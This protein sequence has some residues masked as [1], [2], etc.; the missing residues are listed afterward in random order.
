MRIA[1]RR[2]VS[3]QWHDPWGRVRLGLLV[4]VLVLLVG[5]V[6]YVILGLGVLDAMYQTVT[7]VSTVGFREMVPESDVDTPFKV[8]TIMMILG[9]TG[10]VL[11]TVG[12]L[13]ESLVEGGLTDEIR[14]RRMQQEIDDLE[15]HIIVCGIGQV[16]SAIADELSR[17][18]RE[19]VLVDKREVVLGGGRLF[20]LGDSTDDGVLVKAG[21][22]RASTLVLAMDSDA[23]NLF[24]TLSARAIRPDLFIV[25]R[26]SLASTEPKLLQAG[27]DRVVS[28]H[29]IGGTRMAALVLQP[30]VADF[31]DVVMHDRQL[32]VR[33]SEVPLTESSPFAG[34]QLGVCDI[35]GRSGATVLGLVRPDGTFVTNPQLETELHA[36]DVLIALGTED[37]LRALRALADA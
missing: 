2:T 20:V 8:F 36:H 6:G 29:S 1:P 37:Q 21:V 24:V 7:T 27:A 4:L 10:A 15:G 5:T 22:T 16:G 31:L 26:A 12:A 3:W 30:K 33:L 14:R 32:E 17:A 11:Y 13:F 25:A 35:R 9:G 19:V 28:P 34:S 18:G 23:D